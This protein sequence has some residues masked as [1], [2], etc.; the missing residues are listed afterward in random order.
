[1]E[2]TKKV[3]IINNINKFYASNLSLVIFLG[4]TI[5]FAILQIILFVTNVIEINHISF[6]EPTGQALAWISMAIALGSC[7]VGFVG[8]IMNLRGS[9]SFIY[10]AI[11]QMMLSLMVAIFAGI[12]LTGIALLFSIL[13][14][15]IRY[16]IWKF[17]LLDKWNLSNNLIYI[18]VGAFTIISG[19]LF[20]LLIFIGVIVPMTTSLVPEAKP[21]WT[22][23][24]DAWTSSLIMG[25]A[26]LMIFKSRWAFVLYFISKIFAIA[27]Y[28]EVGNIISIIQL[29]LFV[30]M[31]I[32]GFI[33]WSD[34]NFQLKN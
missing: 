26:L 9:L 2:E 16:F 15:I 21:L 12:I 10:W 29:L 25:A 33:A 32:T 27:N 1:M 31:D 8:A 11:S 3:T 14:T 18:L 4:V 30:T 24:F 7:F 5:L 22:G 20:S 34:K 13:V 28:V 17:E 6:G 19:L 23:Y